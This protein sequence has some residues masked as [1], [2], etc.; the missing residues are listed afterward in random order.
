[1]QVN[2][3]TSNQHHHTTPPPKDMSDSINFVSFNQ[4]Y[5]CVSVGTPQGYKIY[6]CD[7]FGKCFSK[8]DGGMG[9][10]E[11]LFCTSLIAVVGMG[12]Q[13][14]NSPRRL[15]IVN[16]KRQSTICE[17]TF[18][19]AVLG[20]RLNRKRLVVL[21]QDQIYIYDISNMKLV[22][23][24]E[25]SPNPGAVCALSASSSDNN[26]YLVY[27][28]PA[29]SSTAFN[30]GENNINDLSPN[31][32]GDVTIF[33]CNTLQPVNVVEAH[34]TPLACLSLNSDGTLLATASDKGTIIR[35]FSVPKATKLYEFRRGTYPA[36]IFSINFNLS[37][38][39][40]AVSSATETVHIFQLDAGVSSTPEVPQDTELAI[41]TRTPQQKGMASVFR[42]SS[43]SLGKG[44][45]GAV[46]SYLPQT[47]T[48]MWEPLRDFAFIKQ[49]SLPGTRSVVSITSTNP[50]QVL[51]VTL[52]GYFYQYTLDLE[53][54]GECDLIRQYSLLD[55]VEGSLYGP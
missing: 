46:G 45:A 12:D 51:V 26:N 28:F 40:M 36:Q 32:K 39:L 31:R 22:H 38:N 47:F 48:G 53:K 1:M 15:K 6:N 9:I 55:N 35:V 7:P 21:L 44:L 20:V 2:Y 8:A 54:G 33:D 4:D 52:E 30:P 49:T 43:R 5:S 3:Y 16:T 25:T 37:S 11:M 29:P 42:K 34:K 18:P 23:T 19:T 50:P 24:I 17:L 41:P 13:P 27:P 14:Q 10:V